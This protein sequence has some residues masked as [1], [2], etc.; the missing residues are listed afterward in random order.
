MDFSGR[1]KGVVIHIMPAFV[2]S[3][4]QI[5]LAGL[6]GLIFT[7]LHVPAAWL[8]GAVV[9][10][11]LWNLTPWSKPMPLP[12][13]SLALLLSGVSMGA[14]A[15]PAA[16]D[17]M[18]RYPGSIALL[19]IGITC[20]TW[21]SSL[22]LMKFGGWKRDDALLA[23]L[24]GAMSAVVATAVDRNADVKAIVLVQLFRLA[25]LIMILPS[26]IVFLGDSPHTS[27]F[28]GEGLPVVDIRGF[29]VM[30]F[31]GWLIGLVFKRLRMAAPIL[32]G[33]MAISTILHATEFT[34]GVVPPHIA[35]FGL[36]LIGVFTGERFRGITM[37]MARKILPVATGTLG[38][39]LILTFGFAYA[40]AML[41]HVGFADALVAFAPG[42][43]EAMMALAFI[44]GLD[45]IY[46]G[47]HHI[48][49]FLGLGF[50]LPLL[51][52]WLNRTDRVNT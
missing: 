2:S 18:A 52:K 31:G 40:A 26:V 46:V 20:I 1:R 33:G 21:S 4:L 16:L 35:T 23:S 6:G 45:P 49:R 5:C 32:L 39:G 7:V 47:I 38:V 9:A 12:L 24:P 30:T 8:S 43:L 51:I 10:T 22:W 17:A 37:D 27:F 28:V 14:G 36:V 19:A 44:L 34:Y 11:I 41:A 3:L 48:A 50:S 42:G 29:A 13:V 15:T 25:V